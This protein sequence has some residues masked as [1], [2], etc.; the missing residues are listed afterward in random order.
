MLQMLNLKLDVGFISL[1]SHHFLL[2]IRMD[3]LIDVHN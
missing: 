2:I 1:N 3:N